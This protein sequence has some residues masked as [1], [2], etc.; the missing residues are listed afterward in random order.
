MFNHGWGGIDTDSEH[1]QRKGTKRGSWVLTTIWRGGKTGE[2]EETE[3]T[4]REFFLTADGTG[5][6]ADF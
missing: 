1:K 2:Q 3:L 6:D 4:E 5:M